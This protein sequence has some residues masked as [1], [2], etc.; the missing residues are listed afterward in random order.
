MRGNFINNN[1]GATAKQNLANKY[2]LIQ[3]KGILSLCL[4]VR[5]VYP[6]NVT[7]DYYAF[8]RVHERYSSPQKS[9]RKV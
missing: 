7:I 2:I 6:I 8:Y 1:R 5:S 9:Y 3:T 4:P